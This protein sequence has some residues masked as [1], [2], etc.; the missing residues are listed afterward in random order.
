MPHKPRLGDYPSP[1][2]METHPQDFS[3]YHVLLQAGTRMRIEQFDL[4]RN[5]ENGPMVWI[6]GHIL[7]GSLAGNRLNI[8]LISQEAGYSSLKVGLLMVDTN[9]L[10]Q[11]ENP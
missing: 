7:D 9:Y 4:E 11:V 5:P 8:S 2:D 6:R 10:E 1:S 3:S